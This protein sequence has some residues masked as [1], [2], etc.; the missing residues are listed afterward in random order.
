MDGNK[1]DDGYTTTTFARLVWTIVRTTQTATDSIFDNHDE[2]VRRDRCRLVRHPG[3]S[4]NR[5][6]FGRVGCHC[7]ANWNKV[8]LYVALSLASLLLQKILFCPLT[9]ALIYYISHTST[10]R[11]YIDISIVNPRLAVEPEM[12]D[13]AYQP[14]F[15]V[16]NRAKLIHLREIKQV[17]SGQVVIVDSNGVEWL[18][19]CKCQMHSDK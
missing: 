10:D 8:R 15:K 19:I 14:L 7:F 12:V 13:V 18:P 3:R 5:I 9:N 2:A 6:H 16:W 11:D 4:G 1:D 17:S